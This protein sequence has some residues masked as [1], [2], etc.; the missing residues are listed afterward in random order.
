LTRASLAAGLLV[1]GALALAA[2]ARRPAAARAVERVVGGAIEEIET[3][4]GLAGAPAPLAVVARVPS[5]TPAWARHAVARAVERAEH[6][7]AAPGAASVL[8][9]ETLGRPSAFAVRLSLWR[10]GW[11]V[12]SPRPAIGHAAPVV[13]LLTVALLALAD[14]RRPWRA[15]VPAALVGQGTA[16]WLAVGVT[17]PGLSAG[18]RV[19]ASIA[20]GPVARV[21]SAVIQGDTPWVAALLGGLAAAGIVLAWADH[22]RAARGGR[23]LSGPAV[24][25]GTTAVLAGFAAVEAALR[26]GLWDLARTVPG[27]L[28]VAVAGAAVWVFRRASRGLASS[29]A[30]A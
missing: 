23:G 16:A 14:R 4:A 2:A 19:L 1:L 27:G 7:R 30:P 18:D 10:R 5:S 15:A 20:T 25:G 17:A 3:V 21:G 26:L 11:S 28:A 9:V 22:R 24:A 29:E 12:A 13:V 8:Q 6:L